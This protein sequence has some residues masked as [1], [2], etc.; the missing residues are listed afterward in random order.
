MRDALQGRRTYEAR[1]GG[2]RGSS[3]SVLAL[4]T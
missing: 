4:V 1:L 2:D 3:V